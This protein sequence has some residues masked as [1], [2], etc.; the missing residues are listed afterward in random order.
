[1]TFVPDD[2]FMKEV[3]TCSMHCVFYRAV[4]TGILFYLFCL[5]IPSHLYL[6]ALSKSMR[7]ISDPASTVT[8]G[9]PCSVRC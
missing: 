2:G 3:E 8:A 4:K 5:L 6:E 9:L 1:L 7:H